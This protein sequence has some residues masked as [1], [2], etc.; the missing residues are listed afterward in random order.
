MFETFKKDYYR[1]TGTR[2]SI[3]KF[4][5][6]YITEHRMRFVYTY[7]KLQCINKR[8]YLSRLALFIYHRRLKT[9]YGLEINH[10]VKVGVGL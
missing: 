6:L 3:P 4:L 1:M 5:F 10:D 8:R 2:F 7:R 9:R